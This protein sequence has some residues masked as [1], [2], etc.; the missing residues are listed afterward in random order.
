LFLLA[1]YRT[2]NEDP[3]DMTFAGR[4]ALATA[5]KAGSLL[6]L[7]SLGAIVAVF[8]MVMTRGSLAAT[9]SALVCTLVLACIPATRLTGWAFERFDVGRDV[10]A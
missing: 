9:V 3:G 6:M 10:P 7:G 2:V 4:L 5:L 8:A 1:P